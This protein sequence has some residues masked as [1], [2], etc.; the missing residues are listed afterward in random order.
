MPTAHDTTDAPAT[1]PTG[2]PLWFA[3]SMSDGDAHHGA[4]D[5]TGIVHAACGLEFAPELDAYGGPQ[6]GLQRPSDPAHA[7]PDCRK[8]MRGGRPA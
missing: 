2:R 4:R 5:L 8:A 6:T 7:C 3:R 1:Q